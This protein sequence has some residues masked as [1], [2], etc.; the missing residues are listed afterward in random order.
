MLKYFT[1]TI[2]ANMQVVARDWLLTECLLYYICMYIY[3]YYITQIY[4]GITYGRVLNGELYTCK[5]YK[6]INLCWST[7]CFMNHET[8]CRPT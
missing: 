7:G 1:Y 3:I 2:P 4:S 6:L 8:A 5:M